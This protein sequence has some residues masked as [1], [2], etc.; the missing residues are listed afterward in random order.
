MQTL[1]ELGAALSLGFLATIARPRNTLLT[2][3]GFLIA[4]ATLL[5]LLTIP[6]G[7][8]RLAGHTGLSDVAL[9]LTGPA[10]SEAAGGMDDAEKITLIGNLPGV[11][12]DDYGH[13][14]V[15]PQFV[16][17]TKLRRFDGAPSDVTIRGVS[18]A[19][20]QVVGNAARMTS[21][22]TFTPGVDELIA[23][24]GA[25]RAFAAL[26]TG[27]TVAI[28]R[29]PWHVSGNFD[30]GGG[31]WDSEL[32]TDIGSLQAAWN[33]PG[34]ITALWVKLVSPASFNEFKAALLANGSLKG[35]QAQRQTDYYRWQV[36]FIYRY[37]QVAAWGISILLGVAAVLAIANALTM[38]LAARQREIAILRAVGFRRTS[39]ALALFIEVIATG[40]L[41]AC[42]VIVA[43]WLV[44]D[45][46]AV[47][48][49]TFFQSID[50]SL[51]VGPW[52]AAQTIA[53][54]LVLG[55]IAAL[56][57]I[58]RAVRAPLTRALQ[59]E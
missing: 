19:F 54:T 39:L 12:R 7:L 27:A 30:T 45:G 4:S 47:S 42:A 5:S 33:A 1:R 40:F 31:L 36:G 11:A 21:G 17:T 50:F 6:A 16:V 26:D 51:R 13:A 59:G 55:L 35:M 15:A 29:T 20:W 58:A 8:A 44:L 34:R 53:Y 10:A 38:A 14:L 48:S 46:R 52:V 18:P 57:P 22:R 32:W 41:F 2:A 49:A 3:A 43:G 37:T 9:V 23:G 28:R 25:A 24:S 56:W